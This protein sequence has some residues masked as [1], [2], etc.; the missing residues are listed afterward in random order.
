MQNAVE[1]ELVYAFRG[2]HN[3]P[4]RLPQTEI[5]E[6]R[7]WKIGEIRKSIGKN[8]LT[9]NFEQEFAL[10]EKMKLV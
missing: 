2:F 6:G 10:L 4:F 7:F 8:V 3:G 1:S 9:P 5:E